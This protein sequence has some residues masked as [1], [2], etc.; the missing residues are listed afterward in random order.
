MSNQDKQPKKNKNREKKAA[1]K[2]LLAQV[3]KQTVKLNFLRMA[4]RKVRL[5]ASLINGMSVNE[6]EAQ[7]LFIT[8]RAAKPIL[9][10][11]R[12]GVAAAKA[13]GKF[14]IEKLKIESIRV[15]GGPMLKRYTTRAQGSMA[16]IQKKMSHITL[17]LSEDMKAKGSRYTI[18]VHKKTKHLTHEEG[19]KKPQRKEQS[20]KVSKRPRNPGFFKKV[21]QRNAGP[22]GGGASNKGG[23]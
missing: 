13:K 7:L 14:D 10:L 4:P 16:E 1:L 8:R 22:T 12:S 9:K 21:F 11:L 15:D 3:E 6:A 20:E 17:I 19:G 23:E 2:S 18:L 5:V